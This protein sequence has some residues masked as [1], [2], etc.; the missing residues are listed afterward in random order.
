MRTQAGKTEKK[1]TN[2]MLGPEASQEVEIVGPAVEGAVGGHPRQTELRGQRTKLIH[3]KVQ[4]NK[5][6]K[7]VAVTE[8]FPK[9]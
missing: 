9:K 1:V 3:P 7:S 2:P 4:C 5:L 8:S 6:Y